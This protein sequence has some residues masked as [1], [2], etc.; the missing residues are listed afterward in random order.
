MKVLYYLQWVATEDLE[1]QQKGLVG[2]FWW[3][4]TSGITP[5][6]LES[7]HNQSSDSEPEESSACF[8]K[9]L[10]Y[11][12]GPTDHIVGARLFDGSPARTVAMH[13]C[14][15]D[16]PGFNFLRSSLA[17]GL[18]SARHRIKV[19]TGEGLALQYTLHSFGI[20][21]DLLPITETGNVKIKNHYR[22]IKMRSM[23][24]RPFHNKM[25]LP[26]Q[27]DNIIECPGMHDVVFRVGDSYLCH[28]GNAKF[29]GW[30]ESTFEAHDAG[31]KHR[32]AEITWTLVDEV[33]KKGHFLVWDKHWWM[34]M[35]DREKMRIKVMGAFKDHKR[36]LKASSSLQLIHSSTM[37]FMSQD[38][39]KRKRD[40]VS[41]F[42]KCIM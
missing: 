38:G 41:C 34:V 20:P 42:S 17:L 19:H 8:Q 33:L 9:G 22:F 35:E 21:V 18:N 32:K 26:E 14:L 31:G 27:F 39:R 4:T 36:R 7:N 40:E 25:Q 1:T 16:K 5:T 11:V 15:P 28:P 10:S 37:K 29:R 13:I 6:K 12:P 2:V 23:R 30:I 3:P 24:E